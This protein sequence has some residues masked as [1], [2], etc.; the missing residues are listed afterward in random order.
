MGAAAARNV[1]NCTRNAWP[2]PKEA[3]YRQCF[4]SPAASS[5]RNNNQPSIHYR[6][7]TR[8]HDIFHRLFIACRRL[9]GGTGWPGFSLFH[10]F[11]W[12]NSVISLFVNYFQLRPRGYPVE[13]DI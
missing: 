13:D 4:A 10:S 8:E 2:D 6:C 11:E 5:T 12:I 7:T 9:C 3:N 1:P